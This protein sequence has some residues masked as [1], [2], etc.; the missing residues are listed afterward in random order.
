LSKSINQIVLGPAPSGLRHARLLVLHDG[1]LSTSEDGGAAWHA[2]LLPA[3]K[4]QGV[5]AV[6]APRGFGGSEPMLVGLESGRAIR[7][8][9]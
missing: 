1:G 5:T 3:L 9:G 7:V 2:W 6:L 8:R 4:N